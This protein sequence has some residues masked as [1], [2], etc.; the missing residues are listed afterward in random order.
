MKVI[1]RQN[2]GGV[3]QPSLQLQSIYDCWGSKPGL[4]SDGAGRT[5]L[6]R[7]DLLKP[8]VAITEQQS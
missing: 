2:G 5:V 4:A 8:S 6:T 1:K 7:D 3:T